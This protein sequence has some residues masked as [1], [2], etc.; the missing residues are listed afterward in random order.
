MSRRSCRSRSLN[1]G[2]TIL[3]K[4]SSPTARGGRPNP[5]FPLLVLHLT[6]NFQSLTPGVCEKRPS[7]KPTVTYKKSHSNDLSENLNT[8]ANEAIQSFTWLT[9][10]TS[11]MSAKLSEAILSHFVCIGDAPAR[12][13]IREALSRRPYSRYHGCRPRCHQ[14]PMPIA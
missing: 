6:V 12:P 7:K 3:Y 11:Q 5:M 8:E 9:S 10:M 2:C 13:C 4:P 14:W 1:M